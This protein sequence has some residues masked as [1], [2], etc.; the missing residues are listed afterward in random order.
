MSLAAQA[1]TTPASGPRLGT[2][3]WLYALLLAAASAMSASSAAQIPAP[4]PAVQELRQAERSDA[5]G[6]KTRVTL[7]DTAELAPGEPG[8]LRRTYRW[9]VSLPTPL[10]GYALYWPGLLAHAVISVNGHVLKDGSA[11][12]FSTL[13]R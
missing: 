4:A 7:P 9:R 6:A 8:P 2:R 13:L 5:S 12:P 3:A 10:Q 11:F 1:A